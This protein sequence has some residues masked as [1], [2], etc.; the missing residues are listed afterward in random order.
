M[1]VRPAPAAALA[2]ALLC[3]GAPAAAAPAAAASETVTVDATGRIAADGTVTLSGSY[4]CSPGTGP[5]FVSSTIG[6]GSPRAEYGIGGSTALCDGAEHRWE[7]SGRVS[8]D[9]LTAGPAHV[10]AAVM[11]LRPSGIAV[12]PVFHV[13]REQDVTLIRE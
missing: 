5:L 12:W 11:E 1:P 13:V 6:R 10:E 8:S 4:R 2:A 9:F 3:V 7:N